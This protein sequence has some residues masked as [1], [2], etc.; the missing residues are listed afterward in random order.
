[1]AGDSIVDPGNPTVDGGS[2]GGSGAL[3]PI[4]ERPV[5]DGFTRCRN[6]ETGGVADLP[7]EALGWYEAKGWVS[8]DLPA[9]PAP[10]E[11]PLAADPIPT[12][13]P[14]DTPAS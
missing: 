11:T 9:P 6:S 14:T 2:L 1:M 3:A 4:E 5:A 10:P 7:D 12:D 8:T 13:I